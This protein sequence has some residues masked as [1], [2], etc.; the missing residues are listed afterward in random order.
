M[1]K[2]VEL[3][4]ERDALVRQKDVAADI[5]ILYNDDEV[6]DNK[7]IDFYNPIVLLMSEMFRT[8]SDSRVA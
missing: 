1:L 5:N 4:V 8:V 2:R 3:S 6:K 7:S